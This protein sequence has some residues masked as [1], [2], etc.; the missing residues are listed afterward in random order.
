[1]NAQTRVPFEQTVARV[2]E[3]IPVEA[4]VLMSASAHVGILQVAGRPLRSTVNEGDEQAWEAAL[5]DPAHRAAF[6][7]AMEGDPVAR[8]VAAHPE[9]LGEIEVVRSTGQPVTRVYQSLVWKAQAPR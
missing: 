8:A 4:P 2:L 7:I 1:M 9:G 6:V 5:A 3:T